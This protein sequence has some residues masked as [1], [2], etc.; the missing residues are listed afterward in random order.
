MDQFVLP[1]E[2][3]DAAS[4][5]FAALDLLATI[6]RFARPGA[7]PPNQLERDL[8]IRF[9]GSR[10]VS[11]AD[12]ATWISETGLKMQS[13]SSQISSDGELL[14]LALQQLND[15]GAL[16]LL[17]VLDASKLIELEN[18]GEMQLTPRSMTRSAEHCL[19]LRLGYSAENG[20]AYYAASFPGDSRRPIKIVWGSVVAA[21]VSGAMAILPPARP[22]DLDRVTSSLHIMTQALATAHQAHADILDALGQPALV[23]PAQLAEQA[24]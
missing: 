5:K 4:Q 14:R 19:L 22:V 15:A 10:Q 23:A 12:S 17:E 16:Q 21:G 20:Y 13:L 11:F 24:V 7:W 6:G 9:A 8:E 18:T 3:F 2:V 1:P